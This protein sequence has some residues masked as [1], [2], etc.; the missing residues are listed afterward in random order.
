MRLVAVLGFSGRRVNGLHP[1]AAV[2]LRHAERLSAGADAVVFSGRGPGGEA[3]LMHDAW[4]GADVRL[5]REAT[6]GNTAENAA[7]IAAIARELDAD[8][9]VVVTSRWHAPRARLLLR[10][11]LHGTGITVRASAP[12]DRLRPG[13]LAREFAC[14][15]ALPYHLYRS[16][17]KR[18]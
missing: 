16:R 1:L 17:V 7:G 15:L 18:G 4:A 10:A 12:S 6:A 3:H 9:V 2:R 8:E 11:A 14:V 13:L 5:L